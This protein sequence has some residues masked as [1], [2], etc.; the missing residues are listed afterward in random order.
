MEEKLG[1]SLTG[2][3]NCRTGPGEAALDG[4]STV[5]PSSRHRT[6]QSGTVSLSLLDAQRIPATKC[7]SLIWGVVQPQTSAKL[8]GLAWGGS[9]SCD[10]YVVSLSR[11][12]WAW[13][14]ASEMEPCPCGG[15]KG[16]FS[17]KA[18]PVLLPGWAWQPEA[19]GWKDDSPVWW[20]PDSEERV[21][22][23]VRRALEIRGRL[24]L[25]RPDWLCLQMVPK[26][27]AAALNLDRMTLGSGVQIP[28]LFFVGPSLLL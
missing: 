15:P 5:D 28:V 2:G 7:L 17:F 19:R 4:L 21:D 26:I 23:L 14:H 24:L 20:D 12:P 3:T 10:T 18:H 13:E 22:E 16:R 27:E 8:Q 11:R 9:A 6:A 1:S 25:R